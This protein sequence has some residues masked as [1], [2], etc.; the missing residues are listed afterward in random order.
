MPE[1][2]SCFSDP[3]LRLRISAQNNYAQNRAT[4]HSE[5]VFVLRFLTR[6]SFFRRNSPA[7]S[8]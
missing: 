1:M 6:F 5:R 8:N 2:F 4:H 7:F 3:C